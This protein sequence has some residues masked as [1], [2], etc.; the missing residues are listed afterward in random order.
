MRRRALAVLEILTLTLATSCAGW[1]R[2]QLSEGQ[3]LPPRQQVQVWRHGDSRIVHAGLVQH[4][5]LY[6][7]PFTK[8]PGCDS[9]R[10]AIPMS[11]VDSLQLGNLERT[12]LAVVVLPIVL[13]LGLLLAFSIAYGGLGGD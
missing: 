13:G 11:E 7:V 2:T 5:T 9:C 1:R 8:P 3:R 6:A 12:G 10:I 4:D